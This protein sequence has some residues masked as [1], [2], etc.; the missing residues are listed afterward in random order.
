M[1]SNWKMHIARTVVSSP[2]PSARHSQQWLYLT[3]HTAVSLVLFG[4]LHH[5]QSKNKQILPTAWTSARNTDAF[6]L[7]SLTFGVCFC[8]CPFMQ[9]FALN[10]ALQTSK[11]LANIMWQKHGHKKLFSATPPK[12][13]PMIHNI[14]SKCLS[15]PPR[16]FTSSKIPKCFE[17]AKSS[18]KVSTES[19][20]N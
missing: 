3:D 13:I 18:P 8:R 19:N 9:V 7:F 14:L 4:N 16:L 1:S 17:F 5:W 20:F 2:P 10:R 11:P 15:P 12:K 6:S